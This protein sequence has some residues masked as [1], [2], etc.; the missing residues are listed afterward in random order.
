VEHAPAFVRAIEEPPLALPALAQ[1]RVFQLCAERGTTVVF[2]GQAADEVLGGYPYHQR[3]LLVDLL[4]HGRFGG[5]AAELAAISRRERRGR[6]SLLTRGLLLPALTRRTAAPDWLSRDYG[7]RLDAREILE[8]QTDHS[9]DASLLNRRLH[10]DVKWGNVKIILGYG[11]KNAMA[12]SVEARVPFLDRRLVEFAF[13]LPDTFKVGGGE[14]KRILRDY[15]RRHLPS[16]VTERPD[17]MGFGVP[18]ARLMRG[19]LWPAVKEAILENDFRKSPCFAPAALTGL[20][21]GFESGQY[22]DTRTLW[23]LYALALW[24]R[25][26]GV[27][28]G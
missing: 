3:L 18:E 17:R 12:H 10:D 22:Q 1:Y 4:K 13:T 20:V 21:N 9:Q 27:P 28:L 23:R 15:A 26:F 11:D 7:T 14:R 8:A 2:D 19:G 16:E 25:T 24:S 6:L 5:F